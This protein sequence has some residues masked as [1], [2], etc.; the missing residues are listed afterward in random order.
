MLQYSL[1]DVFRGMTLAAVGLGMLVVAFTRLNQPSTNELKML[2]A[3]LVAFGGAFVGYGFA[4]PIKWPPHRMMMG[5]IGMFAAQAWQSGSA[6]GLV[7]YV[8][9]MAISGIVRFVGGRSRGKNAEL[10]ESAGDMVRNR[11]VR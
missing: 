8:V 2:Q 5:A 1:K 10:G 3:F 7:F 4:F 11:E 6:V 9:L